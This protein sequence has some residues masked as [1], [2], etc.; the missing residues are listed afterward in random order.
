METTY[1]VNA[2]GFEQ[3]AHALICLKAFDRIC[4]KARGRFRIV[5]LKG[6]DLMRFLYSDTLDRELNDI[7]LLVVNADREMDF[8]E[9]MQSEGYRPEFSFAL[10]EAALKKKRKVSMISSSQLMPNVDVHFVLITKKF[11]SFTINDFNRDAILRTKVVDDVISE[12]DNVD[13]WLYLAAHLT[14]HFLEGEK[15]Y[16][17]LAL[18]IECFNEEEMLTFVKR[19]QQ[20][21]FER[22]VVAVCARMQSKYPDIAS[23]INTSQLLPDRQGECFVRYIEFMAAHPRRLGRGLRL[24]RYYWEFIFISRKSLRRK[25]FLCLIFSSLGNMQNIY[26]CHVPVAV[27]LYVPHVLIN[28]L[29]I[30]LFSLQYHFVSTY[31]RK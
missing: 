22:V 28:A 12:L 24:A 26:R 6:I 29:G 17:D 15:W 3:Q 23:W 31:Y 11:F 27:L 20:Y 21:N 2:T 1:N 7:D 4:A 13:R 8:I 5:P 18:L 14:F 19:T 30:L 16:R 9:L 10:D 25:S